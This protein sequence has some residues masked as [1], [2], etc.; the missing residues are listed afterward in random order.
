MKKRLLSGRIVL[1]SIVF[2]MVTCMAAPME[3]HAAAKRPAQVK[4]ITVVAKGCNTVKISWKKVKGAKGY[5]V[6]RAASKKGKYKKVKTLKGTGFT[7][8]SLNGGK[9]YYYKVR[10]YKGRKAGKFSAIKGAKANAHIWKTKPAT[11]HSQTVLQQVPFSQAKAPLDPS[12][13]RYKCMCN[14][15]KR[16]NIDFTGV[17]NWEENFMRHMQEVNSPGWE[18]IAYTSVDWCIECQKS[19]EGNLGHLLDYDHHATTHPVETG[20]VRHYAVKK[21]AWVQDSQPY[22]YCSRCG[23]RK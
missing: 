7:D 18:E 12:Y 8:K 4:K 10:A 1:L 20:R 22:A 6:Y 14:D 13:H 9:Q 5:Q 3:V 2:M 11:G 23:T 15:C 19:I 17:T 16:Y 21:T